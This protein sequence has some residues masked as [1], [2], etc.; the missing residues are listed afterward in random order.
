MTITKEKK[1][2]VVGEF[3]QGDDDTGSPEVQIAI[4]TTRINALTEHMRVHKKDYSTRRGL[5]AMVSRRRRLLDY[6]RQKDPQ[7]YLDIIGRL[8]IRK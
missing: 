1:S 4:L 5:L 3:K 6:V 8:G 7:R 2:E